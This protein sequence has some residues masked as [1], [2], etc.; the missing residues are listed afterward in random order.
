MSRPRLR[1]LAGACG[2]LE[3]YRALDGSRRSV[4]DA[5]CEALIAAM[6][7][8][9]ST[10]DAAAESLRSQ[11]AR[12][13]SRLVDAVAVVKEGAP[14]KLRARGPEHWRGQA[15]RWTLVLSAED[16]ESKQ[17]NGTVR[18][19][20]RLS[21]S[22]PCAA[23]ASGVYAAHFRF[24][25]A[26]Q[27]QTASQWIFATPRSCVEVEAS[28]GQRRGYGIWTHVYALMRANDFGI[29]DLGHLGRLAEMAEEEG[30]AFVA[31]QP[32]HALG[33]S[34]DATSPYSPVSRLFRNPIYLEIEA[35]PEFDESD[36]ARRALRVLG[37]TGE[38]NLLRSASKIDYQAVMRVKRVVLD[39]LFAD[40]QTTHGKAPTERGESFR[41]YVDREGAALDRYATYCALADHLGGAQGPLTDWRE[42]PS[43]LHDPRGHAVHE[44]ARERPREVAFHRWLQFEF[45]R[46]ILERAHDAKA[47]LPLGLMGDLALGSGRGSADTWMHRELFAEGAS[48]GAPPDAFAEGQNWD[49]PPLN[50]IRS[51]ED[52]H[53]YWRR[54]LR[55]SFEGMGA[56]RI[57]H[58]MGLFRQ[59]WIPAGRPAAEGAYVEAPS[60]ELLALLSIES[61]RAGA[62]VVGEDLGT[63]PP[64]L[65]PRLARAG[66]LSTRVLPF[67]RTETGFRAAKEYGAR[68]YVTVHTHDL[69]PFQ[70]WCEGREL[71]LRFDAG[72]LASPGALEAAEAERSKDVSMLRRR[73]R[74]DGWL[75]EE[76]KATDN[77]ELARAV[78]EFLGS[79]P[80]P[81]LAVSVDDLVG[82][83]DPLNLPGL[84]S[85]QYPNWAHRMTVEL[86]ELFDHATGR[87]ILD[88]IPSDRRRAST[89][90]RKTKQTNLLRRQS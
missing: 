17:L 5:T 81:L 61:H 74:R 48:L 71:E 72:E 28:L 58:V 65:G 53:A 21:L 64:A 40:F 34:R 90:K 33:N 54:V 85:R 35:I 82:E 46:Q 83:R 14:A 6:G 26:G 27:I 77:T 18:V 68:A 22:I 63:R 52:G 75:S 20:R 19:G 23:L 70:G 87:V 4:S 42:W 37:E 32:F 56:L 84:N 66:I 78:T 51:R 73:L 24:E 31:T 47:R 16:G 29:G 86:D 50:P 39:P 15:V 60:Q 89:R 62:V 43:N 57:D 79:T 41:S 36:A 1:A 3:E 88:A 8:D 10:E 55:C 59:F 44:F 9:G 12:E 13:Q 7:I 38:L 69:P 49:L 25:C 30:A 76:S 45:E 67:E 2:V 80:A 11:Q